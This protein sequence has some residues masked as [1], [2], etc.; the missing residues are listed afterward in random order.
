MKKTLSLLKPYLHATMLDNQVKE[1]VTYL[2]IRLL[3]MENP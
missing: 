1:K 2:K 3:W